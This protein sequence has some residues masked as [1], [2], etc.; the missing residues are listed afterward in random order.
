VLAT[1]VPTYLVLQVLC[2]ASLAC[3]R[4]IKVYEERQALSWHAYDGN[5][6][7]VKQGGQATA[8]FVLL[9]APKANLSLR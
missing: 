1:L 3:P 4:T 2:K 5:K 9:D 8:V 7:Q 6:Q